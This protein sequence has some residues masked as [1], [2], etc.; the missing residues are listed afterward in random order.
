MLDI[1]RQAHRQFGVGVRHLYAKL[2]KANR[3]TCS[4]SSLYRI[5]RRCGAL[6][7]HP[8][9]PKPVWTRYAKAVPRE[10]AQMDIKYLPE[11]RFQLTLVDDCSRYL[12][13]T[14][15]ER[16]TMEAV[17]TALP[18]LLQA[19]ALLPAMHPDR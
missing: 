12:A 11:S 4:L 1:I 18:R 16:R 5:L 17:C 8:R 15:L 13:A 10:R 6:V 9:K 14:V 3:I 2:R 19:V 7:R